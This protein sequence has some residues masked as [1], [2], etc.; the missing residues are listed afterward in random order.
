MPNDKE[1]IFPNDYLIEEEH[2]KECHED[3]L[4]FWMMVMVEEVMRYA[5]KYLHWEKKD[6]S[7]TDAFAE[8]YEDKYFSVLY[9]LYYLTK[10]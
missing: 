9:E 8:T 5:I 1:I 10:E 7:K 2:L 3:Y 6:H 4:C